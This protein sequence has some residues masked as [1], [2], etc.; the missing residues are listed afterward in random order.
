MFFLK[1]GCSLNALSYSVVDSFWTF[2]KE[3]SAASEFD[4]PSILYEEQLPKVKQVIDK[5]K[6]LQSL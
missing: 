3:Q 6:S 2:L 4:N 1:G 5:V